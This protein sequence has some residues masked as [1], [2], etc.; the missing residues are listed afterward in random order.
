[1]LVTTVITGHMHQKTW[2]CHCMAHSLKIKTMQNRLS[3]HLVPV[4]IITSPYINF[5]V[6]EEPPE[7]E[8]E[9]TNYHSLNCHLWTILSYFAMC[10][11]QAD[12]FQLHTLYCVC[13]I[14]KFILRV[15]YYQHHKQNPIYVFHWKSV[16]MRWESGRRLVQITRA[17]LCCVCF[18][19]SQ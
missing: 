4:Q 18:Y 6:S 14:H 7:F 2:Q 9:T 8:Y 10:Y 12:I 11:E 13:K 17:R 5:Q 16:P 3:N 1:M 15:M 19:L